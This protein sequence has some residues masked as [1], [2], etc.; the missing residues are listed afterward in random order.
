M[1]V[2]LRE[3][4]SQARAFL[5]WAAV[6]AFFV[7]V[8]TYKFTGM[9]GEAGD[10]AMQLLES[11][12]RP[13][14]A[15]FGLAAT[16]AMKFGGFFAMIEFYAVLI[17]SAWAL[18]LGHA[19]VSRE[20]VDG[21]DEFLFTK[22]VSRVRVLAEKLAAALTLLVAMT[23]ANALSAA[24]AVGALGD[25]VGGAGGQT[26]GELF[27]IVA[28]GSAWVLLSGLFFLALGVALAALVGSAGLASRCGLSLLACAYAASVAYDLFA[29][30]ASWL[31]A[32]SPIR[33]LGMDDVAHGV[34][35]ATGAA[36]LV[37]LAAAGLAAGTWAFAR[38]DL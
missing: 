6:L 34:V 15:M 13:V 14:L 33:Y 9:Q 27:A 20:I 38:R 21:T 7:V 31:R 24:G 22:P 30:K 8:G 37:A 35:T 3:L 36:A 19:V 4:R 16:N 18:G 25:S 17:A 1:N 12:P 5:V 26:G 11:F 29:D 32:L 23:C 2:Y 10:Q 28:A